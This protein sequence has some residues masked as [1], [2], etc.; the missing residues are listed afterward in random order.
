MVNFYW[1]LYEFEMC[2]RVL[3]FPKGHPNWNVADHLSLYLAVA[4]VAMLPNGG[5]LYAKFSLSVINEN[6]EHC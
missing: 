1:I 5:Y 6:D 4:D 2:R 3:I